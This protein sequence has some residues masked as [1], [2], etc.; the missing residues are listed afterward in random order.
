MFGF[1]IG[2]LL[3]FLPWTM[4]KVYPHRYWHLGFRTTLIIV[5]MPV[6]TS[7]PGS[8]QYQSY[9]IPIVISGFIT[10][11]YMFRFKKEWFD[12]VFIGLISLVQLRLG[13]G[14]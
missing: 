10:Q 11:F 3:P 8:G 4:N 12:K 14:S 5:N 13:S 1:L 2:F 7:I 6:L 9:L